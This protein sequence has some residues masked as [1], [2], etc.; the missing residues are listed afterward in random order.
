M[1]RFRDF[2]CT[3]TSHTDSNL[4]HHDLLYGITTIHTRTQR[5]LLYWQVD[6]LDCLHRN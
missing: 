1:L 4:Q 2:S 6:I 5:F 3:D